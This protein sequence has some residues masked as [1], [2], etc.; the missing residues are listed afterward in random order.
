MVHQ[1]QTPP[2]VPLHL[3]ILQALP[4]TSP[5]AP[6]NPRRLSPPSSPAEMRCRQHFSPLLWLAPNFQ[7]PPFVSSTFF[8]PM[9][10]REEQSCNGGKLGTAYSWW[11]R[12]FFAQVSENFQ[13]S[14]LVVLLNWMFANPP[15]LWPSLAAALAI[16][17]PFKYFICFG[18]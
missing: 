14:H 13:G 3:R 8:P 11:R 5:V 9:G 10:G 18:A 1:L 6:V 15:S 16:W 17:V 4:P 2:L 7:L 12:C